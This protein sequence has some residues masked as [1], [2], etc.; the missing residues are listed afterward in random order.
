ML[1]LFN[2]LHLLF[3]LILFLAPGFVIA[4]FLPLPKLAK[5]NYFLFFILLLNLTLLPL[6]LFLSSYFFHLPINSLFIFGLYLLI[7]ILGCSLLNFR[8]KKLLV[9]NFSLT[10]LTLLIAAIS[11]LSLGL[12]RTIPLPGGDSTS[13]L[14]NSAKLLDN[15]FVS[16]VFDRSMVVTTPVAF[17]ILTG[18]DLETSIKLMVLTLYILCIIGVYLL[19]SLILRSNLAMAAIFITTVNFGLIRLTWDMYSFMFGIA[20][21]LGILLILL[22][23]KTNLLTFFCIGLLW[24][25]LFNTHGIVSF[26]SFIILGLPFL[27]Y[28]FEFF[29][30]SKKTP[31]RLLSLIIFV[32]VFLIS[33]QPLMFRGWSTVV[34]LAINPITHQIKPQVNTQSQSTTILPPE[35]NP[36]TNNPGKVT[37]VSLLSFPVFLNDMVTSVSWPLIILGLIGFAL[38]LNKITTN[39]KSRGSIFKIVTYSLFS[40]SFFLLTQQPLIGLNWYSQ[41]F[42]LSLFIVAIPWSLLGLQFFVKLFSQKFSR[43]F[44]ATI[45]VL[46][47]FP[48]IRISS[49]FLLHK[50]HAVI[51]LEEYIF[52]RRIPLLIDNLD[53]PVIS[54]ST[55]PY[56]PRGL[57]PQLRII[58]LS[59]NPACNDVN[60][61]LTQT[62]EEKFW[63]QPFLL[64]NDINNS[65]NMFREL[66]RKKYYIIL[67]P[68]NSCLNY[69]VFSEKNFQNIYEQGGYKLLKS[70]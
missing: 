9:F 52:Y 69:Q 4:S 65:L 35:S 28:L 29:R 25:S 26:A 31:N 24:G 2:F 8:H 44:F 66:S 37:R 59:P 45:L 18:V 60:F 63:Y 39:L 23:R 13:Y 36:E 51:S 46:I 49:E 58:T 7:F 34:K 3:G 48:S 6:S 19:S 14:Y 43:I 5:G 70:I 11:Y 22:S 57:N 1:N 10:N 40:V 56:W 54:F 64:S 50:Y 12:F 21:L 16:E 33:S 62:P 53:T 20:T 42:I 41:R 38:T 27:I 55:H 47:S 17:S 68:N 15:H 32:M 61:L 30:V 67:P